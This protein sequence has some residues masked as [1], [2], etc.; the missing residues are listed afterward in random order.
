MISAE[1]DSAPPTRDVQF[2]GSQIDQCVLLSKSLLSLFPNVEHS[3][4]VVGELQ[5]ANASKQSKI[6]GRLFDANSYGYFRRLMVSVDSGSEGSESEIV[7]VG[8]RNAIMERIALHS[9]TFHVSTDIL[10]IELETTTE[11]EAAVTDSRLLRCEVRQDDSAV[12]QGVRLILNGLL[13]R[14]EASGRL[15][16][17]WTITTR[18]KRLRQLLDKS[19]FEQAACDL[20]SSVVE[21]SEPDLFMF[22]CEAVWFWVEGPLPSAAVL[23]KCE[24]LLR[25]GLS[26]YDP[27]IRLS[28]VVSLAKLLVALQEAGHEADRCDRLQDILFTGVLRLSADSYSFTSA[29]FDQVFQT[30]RRL[31]PSIEGSR[32]ESIVDA[33]SAVRDVSRK[34]GDFESWLE[35]GVD[36]P[37]LLSKVVWLAI[38]RSRSVTSASILPVQDA[39]SGTDVVVV[40]TILEGDHDLFVVCA[41]QADVNQ[42]ETCDAVRVLPPNAQKLYFVARRTRQAESF[43]GRLIAASALADLLTDSN[44]LNAEIARQLENCRN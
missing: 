31:L 36:D 26:H 6:A 32:F 12:G 15:G 28:S 5:G 38:W 16:S 41:V 17:Y 18:L 7:T 4:S 21:A 10:P 2:D 22:M 43:G 44:K 19:E 35:S 13:G 30:C 40:K 23:D 20:A 1:N 29:F 14:S 34:E 42:I 11:G 24:Q 8:G 33:L 9:M 25:V 39:G 27:N 3:V 37:L